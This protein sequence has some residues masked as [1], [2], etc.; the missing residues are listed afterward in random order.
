MRQPTTPR[1]MRRHTAVNL[2]LVGIALT[3]IV[4]STFEIPGWAVA[5]FMII[6]LM[7][8]LSLT[9]KRIR[10]ENR[11]ARSFWQIVSGK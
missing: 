9:P 2:T 6:V 11:L 1:W 10:Q 5:V 3:F 8:S 7:V 4:L